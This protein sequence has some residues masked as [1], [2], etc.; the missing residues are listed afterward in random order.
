MKRV[1][2]RLLDQGRGL[3]VSTKDNSFVVP[4]NRLRALDPRMAPILDEL[5]SDELSR[6]EALIQEAQT[7]LDA[8]S[9][10]RDELIG[11]A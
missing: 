10:R 6:L 7:R 8:L 3:Y 1:E 9:A 2:L 11:E 4:Y 5:E